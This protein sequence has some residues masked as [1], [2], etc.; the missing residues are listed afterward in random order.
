M[1]WAMR[2]WRPITFPRSLA[3]TRKKTSGR[4]PKSPQAAE[5]V[6]D[7][8]D[9][10]DRPDD[11]KAPLAPHLLILPTDRWLNRLQELSYRYRTLL[12]SYLCLSF[13]RVV[14]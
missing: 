4:K 14:R 1:A 8:R 3:W 10:Y 6:H 12:S 9:E 13:Y 7:H 5:K 11:S 2:P